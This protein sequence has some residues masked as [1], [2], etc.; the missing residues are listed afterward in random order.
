MKVEQRIKTSGIK[1]TILRPGMLASNSIGWWA[2]QIRTGDVV[3]WP[4][5]DAPTAP[6]DE[7]DIASVAVHT[8]LENGHEGA[9]YILTGPQSLS[10]FEQLSI[11]GQ[12][13]GRKLKIEEISQEEAQ[14]QWNTS[15]PAFIKN[16]L[17][18]SWAAA[19]GQPAYISNT[20]EKVTGTPART[21]F[22]W[23]SDNAH[24]FQS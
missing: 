21:F 22:E 19:I 16:M 6:I 14:S 13:V 10:Q 17:L 15:W 3:R 1:Y 12:A 4:Y 9:E 20:V 2:P 11:I 5:L 8:L 24:E 7:F 23:A 18:K